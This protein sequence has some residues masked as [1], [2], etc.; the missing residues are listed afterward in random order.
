MRVAFSP[1]RTAE[2]PLPRRSGRGSRKGSSSGSSW[3]SVLASDAAARFVHGR[4]SPAAGRSRKKR[5]G[6]GGGGGGGGIGGR[7]E[8]GTGGG[9]PLLSVTSA[10]RIDVVSSLPGDGTVAA[11][12]DSAAAAA[13]APIGLDGARGCEGRPGPSAAF[14]PP[15]SSSS[16]SSSSCPPPLPAVVAHRGGGGR[17]GFPRTPVAALRDSNRVLACWDAAGGTGPDEN[18][19]AARAAGNGAGTATATA[20]AAAAVVAMVPF[21]PGRHAVGLVP[22]PLAAPGAAGVLDDGTA[23]VAAVRTT[24]TGPRRV[25]VAYLPRPGADGGGGAMEG[26]AATSGAGGRRR[27]RGGMASTQPPAPSP[28]VGWTH[29]LTLASPAGDAAPTDGGGGGREGKRKKQ[30]RGT[31]GGGD[32]AAAGAAAAPG[33]GCTLRVLWHDPDAGA[34]RLVRHRATLSWPEVEAEAEA[35]EEDG[36]EGSRSGP[37]GAAPVLLRTNHDGGHEYPPIE[38]PL[39]RGA[40]EDEELDS[41]SS[42]GGGAGGV[43]PGSVLCARLDSASAAVAY[44]VVWPGGDASSGA[45]MDGDEGEEEEEEEEEGHPPSSSWYCIH[46]DARVGE[47]AAGPFPLD[48]PPGYRPVRLGGLSPSLVASLA[49]RDR[50]ASDN[51]AGSGPAILTVYDTRRSVAVCEVSDVAGDLGL[52]PPPGGAPYDAF[53]LAS[54]YRD[55]SVAVLATAGAGAS[56]TLTVAVSAL[57]I[58]E[59]PPPAAVPAAAGSLKRGYSLAAAVASA[60]AVSDD[61]A[62]GVGMPPVGGGDLRLLLPPRPADGG[63]GSGGGTTATG[64]LVCG[65]LRAVDEV[66]VAVEL[67]HLR[68]FLV[69]PPADGEGGGPISFEAAYDA[70]V[71]GFLG[72]A[73]AAAA[74]ADSPAPNGSRPANGGTRRTRKGASAEPLPPASPKSIASGLNGNG[75]LAQRRSGPAD[76]PRTF[77]DGAVDVAIGLVTQPTPYSDGELAPQSLEALQVL[78]KLI[79]TGW[80]SARHHLGGGAVRSVLLACRHIDDQASTVALR[81]IDGILVHCADDVP[82]ATL[83][84]ALHYVLCYATPEGVA[85]FYRAEKQRRGGGFVPER[86]GILTEQR[87][88]MLAERLLIEREAAAATKKTKTK[89][90]AKKNGKQTETTEDKEGSVAPSSG[91]A[92]AR[93]AELA[94]LGDDL[95]TAVLAAGVLHFADRIVTHSPANGALLRSALL[96]TLVHSGRGEVSALLSVLTRLLGGGS[97]SGSRSGSRVAQWI[98]ALADAHVPALLGGGER[99]LVRAARRA[100]ATSA[101]GAEVVAG[102]RDLIEAAANPPPPPQAPGG[103]GS[104]G[105]AVTYDGSGRRRLTSVRADAAPDGGGGP[106][107][108]YSIERL[109]F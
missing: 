106:T 5:R 76:L 6:S 64:A 1:W 9:H 46:L 39:P 10:R 94:E 57:G 58:V 86:I 62:P 52:P 92:E 21:P 22:S 102:M 77:V 14:L 53:D 83:V 66:A 16:S 96:D 32:G 80:V 29:L 93:L 27:R 88:D 87:Q 8:D 11:A 61:V 38:L 17:R 56:A 54:D 30:P 26:A 31:G 48:L 33:G 100:V 85:A 42:S 69:H 35:E 105:R 79:R 13:A 72:Q 90:K 109:V 3:G 67:D 78:A 28:A 82:E 70:A 103:S 43:D 65:A 12:R 50:A 36:E 25:G 108:P 71:A 60:L 55:G 101:A 47:V 40:E 18:G 49:C 19:S 44:R 24:A 51:G 41:L 34:L 74:A 7:W 75:G 91:A 97:G 98:S 45:G 95:R 84:A 107:P 37:P 59:A 104:G 63:S 2:F 20:T 15:S 73:G 81:I 68:E 89:K 99:N 23:Y 4:P